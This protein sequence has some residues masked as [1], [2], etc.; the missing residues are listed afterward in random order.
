M[1]FSA[2]AMIAFKKKASEGKS[3]AATDPDTAIGALVEVVA[4]TQD[5]A[6][7]KEATATLV[8]ARRA[9]TEQTSE[10]L[11]D[12]VMAQVRGE[13][14]VARQ[15]LALLSREHPALVSARVRASM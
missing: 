14:E 3:K 5:P 6:L 11:R 8:A 12:A 1:D 9:L 7:R 10:R 2:D 13:E 15:K 4:N